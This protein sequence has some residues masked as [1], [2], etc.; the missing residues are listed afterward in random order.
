[1][2]KL[3]EFN[4][5]A[6]IYLHSVGDESTWPVKSNVLVSSF[7]LLYVPTDEKKWNVIN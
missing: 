4:L 2:Q 3:V 6:Y 5:E 1:M 7:S